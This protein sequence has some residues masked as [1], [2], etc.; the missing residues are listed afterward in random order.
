[1]DNIV[2]VSKTYINKKLETDK[3]IK[4]NIDNI[5]TSKDDNISKLSNNDKVDIVSSQK[6]F[7]YK[8]NVITFAEG[9]ELNEYFNTIK[10]S[11]DL[12]TDSSEIKI[13]ETPSKYDTE[14]FD[15]V[16]IKDE[17]SQNLFNNAL[18]GTQPEKNNR[19]ELRELANNEKAI[20]QADPIEKYII[21]EK[22]SQVTNLNKK[23]E[24]AIVSIIKFSNE[25]GDLKQL[26]EAMLDDEKFYSIYERLS[27][28]NKEI[29]APLISNNIPDFYPK[30]INND[31]FEEI[32]RMKDKGELGKTNFDAIIV[33]GYTPLSS[34]N[35]TPLTERAKERLKS[36]VEDFK[37]GKAPFIIVS[38]GSVH[39][40]RTRI[41][42]AKEM[43]DYLV[44][45]LKVPS[46]RIIVEGLARHSTTNL[47]NSGRIMLEHGLKKAVIISDPGF[48]GMVSQSDYFNMPFFNFR[49]LNNH[50]QWSP[51]EIKSIDKNFLGIGNK[52]NLFIPNKEITKKDYVNDPLDP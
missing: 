31:T 25:Q 51:G 8:N 39:P 32:K 40:E 2:N 33:P 4:T 23:D 26:V 29:V 30:E 28:D 18:N 48:M 41:N 19:K 16:Q 27:K 21:I 17:K 45:E 38:G 50:G 49:Y 22:I 14:Y 5:Q 3:N 42:E 13:N 34:K 47:R 20:K 52:R 46:N 1:M 6:K 36:A 43:R 10:K 44:K 15:D 11:S 9:K 24:Q 7:D 12:Q 37:A 35:P